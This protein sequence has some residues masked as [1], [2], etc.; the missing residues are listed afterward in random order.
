MEQEYSILQC[1]HCG[2]TKK[3]FLDG[4]FPNKK[5]KKWRDENGRMWNG[6]F[7]PP[8]HSMKMAQRKRI[9]KTNV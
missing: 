7:C 8:C 9:N 5:D 2:E 6:N 1:K 4:K 3:R